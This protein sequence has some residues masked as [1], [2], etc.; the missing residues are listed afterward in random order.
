MQNH[1]TANVPSYLLIFF[2]AEFEHEI[3]MPLFVAYAIVATELK[4]SGFFF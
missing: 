4:F 1:M 2:T 3:S